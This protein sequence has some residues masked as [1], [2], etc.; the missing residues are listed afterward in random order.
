MVLKER[1]YPDPQ[2]WREITLKSGF[3]Y[4]LV[5]TTLRGE[6]EDNEQM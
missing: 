2:R 4:S 5:R 6:D 3:F 1:R